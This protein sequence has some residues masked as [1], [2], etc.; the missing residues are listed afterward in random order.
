M[1]TKGLRVG[2]VGLTDRSFMLIALTCQVTVKCLY[3]TDLGR[4]QS[5]RFAKMS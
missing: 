5:L 3:L 2:N 1:L 4:F